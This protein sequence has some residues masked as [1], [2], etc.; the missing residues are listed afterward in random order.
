MPS[1]G[2][3]F[4]ALG[5]DVDDTQLKGFNDSLKGTLNTMLELAGVSLSV[6]GFKN[7][8]DGASQTAARFREMG[9]EIGLSVENMQ[10]FALA[11]N[12]VNPN[13]SVTQ[14][15]ENYAKFAQALKTEVELYGSG[16]KSGAIALLTGRGVSRGDS[17]DDVLAAIHGNIPNIRRQQGPNADAFISDLLNKSGIGQSSRRYF[18]LSD[19]EIRQ[20]TDQLVIQKSTTDSLAKL[21]DSAALAGQWLGQLGN[22]IAGFFASP[23]GKTLE[24]F[25]K[26]AQA[27]HEG[28]GMS[29]L[30]DAVGGDSFWPKMASMMTG[31]HL[32]G[33]EYAIT[34]QWLGPAYN[35]IKGAADNTRKNEAR[36]K[37]I[38]QL[39]SYGWSSAQAAG[40]ADRLGEE[41]A[42]DYTNDPRKHGRTEN[43]Y[44][45][46]QWQ[47]PRQQDFADIYHH[48]IHNS[49]MEEQVAFLNYEMTK[50]QYRKAGDKLRTMTNQKDIHD[51]FTNDVER[52]AQKIVYQTNKVDI[53]STAPARELKI[54]FDEIAK[55]RQSNA[56]APLDN[57][58]IR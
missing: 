33:A 7:L 53:T 45:I 18:D 29:S 51:H 24:G 15:Q 19:Q 28:H 43:A 42:Y 50:G 49:T 41:S 8:M 17:V 6:A 14:F 35:A 44:G 47:A 55:E 16:E 12:Q 32:E 5:F 48:D 40:I 38:D 20:R 9:A 22:D 1:L 26:T 57:S 10:R 21:A 13:V 54:V 2:E 34:G 37:I 30:A 46:A 25:S 58:T 31:D 56:F 27:F 23:T 39:K 11:A 4:I 52:P 36:G 3:L